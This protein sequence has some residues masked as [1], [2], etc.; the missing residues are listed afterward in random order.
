M[1]NLRV[2][3][4]EVEAALQ[5]G[6][7]G[8]RTEALRRVT[9]VFASGREELSE[10]QVSLFD[11]VLNY[12]VVHIEAETLAETSNRLSSVA[13]G[14]RRALR[15]LASHDAIEVAGPVLE[16]SELL[17][18]TDLIEIAKTKSQAHQLKIAGRSQLNEAV[19]EVLIDG[20]D[21]AVVNR[22]AV[23][24]G[25]RFSD[26]GFSKMIV[27]ADG[28]DGLA[29][30]IASR[31][32]VPPRLFREL[33]MRASETVRQR[34][35]ATAP[36]A[37]RDNLQKILNDISGQLRSQVASKHYA[38]AERTVGTFSQD[39]QLT[40]SK[41][42]EFAQ[43]QQRDEAVAALSVL[44]AVPIEMVDRLFYDTEQDGLIVLCKAV[45]LDW[46]TANAVLSAR[47]ARTI[48]NGTP[49]QYDDYAAI[50]PQTAQRL[51]RFWQ[52]RQEV[53][54]VQSSPRDAVLLPV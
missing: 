43:K 20:G 25:A 27:M 9:D 51:L 12:L 53:G 16:N 40:R 1:S 45:A 50:T 32:D 30:T 39:T 42:R 10:Q 31:T 7:P 6:S 2:L 4:A 3:V 35:L 11:D 18:D 46:N 28:D 41:L 14:P 47:P 15:R 22:V 21:S 54:R 36:P 17:T 24:K 23:N 8:K 49:M 48:G 29:S 13:K 5:S 37:A 52:T 34:M 38:K 44:S 19:T 33:L 26:A